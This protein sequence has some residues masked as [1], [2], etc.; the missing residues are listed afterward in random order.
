MARKFSFE[1]WSTNNVPQDLQFL[2]PNAQCEFFKC[3]VKS[4]R[5]LFA[6]KMSDVLTISIR[7][8]GSVDRPRTDK[9][10]LMAK[11]MTK[12]GEENNIC[13]SAGEPEERG[14]LAVHNAISRAC[15]VTLKNVC[16]PSCLAHRNQHGGHFNG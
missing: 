7:C 11:A 3:I 6:S 14:A 15:S 4:Y 5:N 13:L 9:T 2:S 1:G 12:D 8:D 16:Q 10:N